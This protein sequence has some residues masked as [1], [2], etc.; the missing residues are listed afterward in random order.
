MQQC[1]SAV[2]QWCIGWM[3]GAEGLAL[4]EVA[5]RAGGRATSQ[6]PGV[7]PSRSRPCWAVARVGGDDGQRARL[8][9][10]RSAASAGGHKH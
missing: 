3:V 4:V 1:S 7:D 5:A 6:E 10:A 2:V 9:G 8:L